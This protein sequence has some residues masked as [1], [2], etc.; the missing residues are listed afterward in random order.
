MQ[1]KSALKGLKVFIFVS[2]LNRI[3]TVS[4][5]ATEDDGDELDDTAL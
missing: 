1:K 5:E 2:K 4:D 3:I